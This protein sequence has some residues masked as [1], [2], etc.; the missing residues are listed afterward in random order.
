ME[1]LTVLVIAETEE[2][3]KIL[4]NMANFVAEAGFITHGIF[5]GSTNPGRGDLLGIIK[6]LLNRVEDFKEEAKPIRAG[7]NRVGGIKSLEESGPNMG[8]AAKGIELI[9]VIPNIFG[10]QETMDIINRRRDVTG[11][12]AFVDGKRRSDR[13]FRNRWKGEGGR[14]NS[15]VLS[16]RRARRGIG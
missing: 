11:N 8:E 7:K 16:K 4:H 2:I 10:G 3:I 13:K 5:K 9:S 15:V 1:A 12:V 6:A 14:S